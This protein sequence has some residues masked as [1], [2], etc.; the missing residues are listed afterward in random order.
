MNAANS[1]S[2]WDTS[3]MEAYCHAC[4]A[5]LHKSMSSVE[6]KSLGRTTD[7]SDNPSWNSR[8]STAAITCSHGLAPN[9]PSKR[10]VHSD[11]SWNDRV[12]DVVQQRSLASIRRDD[13]L[14]HDDDSSSAPIDNLGIVMPVKEAL[15]PCDREEYRTLFRDDIVLNCD[16]EIEDPDADDT[17]AD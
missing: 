15:A 1:Q 8:D 14:W 17:M 5:T 11:L 9:E 13:L 2:T 16:S 10:S 6:M 4:N 12:T 7:Q 3:V